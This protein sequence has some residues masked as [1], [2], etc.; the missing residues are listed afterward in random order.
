MAGGEREREE[1]DWR[2]VEE[3]GDVTGVEGGREDRERERCEKVDTRMDRRVRV[4]KV[5]EG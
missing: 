1:G 4:R 5:R 3:R 2:V